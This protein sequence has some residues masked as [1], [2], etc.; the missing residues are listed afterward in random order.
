MCA[1][2]AC[3]ACPPDTPWQSRKKADDEDES[4]TSEDEE[5]AL[6]GLDRSNIIEGSA[7]GRRRGGTIDYSKFS[8]SPPPA[9]ASLPQTPVCAPRAAVRIVHSLRQACNHCCALVALVAS[10]EQRGSSA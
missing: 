5:D 2:A 10:V 9:V 8:P 7:R 1:A 6:A 4:D 3:L